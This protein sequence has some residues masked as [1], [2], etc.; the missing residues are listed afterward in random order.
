[1][2]RRSFLG[3]IS[4]LTGLAA[5]SPSSVIVHQA[6]DAVEVPKSWGAYARVFTDPSSIELFPYETELI[7]VTCLMPERPA[8]AWRSFVSV[9]REPLG[10]LSLALGYKDPMLSVDEIQKLSSGV[11]S[12]RV[13]LNKLSAYFRRPQVSFTFLG[14]LKSVSPAVDLEGACQTQILVIELETFQQSEE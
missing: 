14:T 11:H 2:N 4:S 6:E 3:L 10:R 7:D 8:Q 12:Y 13:V 9:P 1:M 5:K